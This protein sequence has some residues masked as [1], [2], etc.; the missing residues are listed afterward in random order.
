MCDLILFVR[1]SEFNEKLS[2]IY[3][4]LSIFLSYI[5]KNYFILV[6][7]QEKPYPSTEKKNLSKYRIKKKLILVPN[8]KKLIQVPNKNENLIQV[9]N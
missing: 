1:L 5:F 3:W 2:K 7:N 4:I 9:S 6:P 8:K